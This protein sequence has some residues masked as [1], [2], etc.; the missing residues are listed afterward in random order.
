MR[1]RGRF[2]PVIAFRVVPRRR[3][4]KSGTA[5][6]GSVSWSRDRV[7]L[8]R[9]GKWV[10]NL[11]T[12]H[13]AQADSLR[14]CQRLRC[15][16]AR[17]KFGCIPCGTGRFLTRM[18]APSLRASACKIWLHSTRY[19]QI[20]YANASAFAAS[21]RVQNLA[22]FHA[23]QADSLRECQHLRCEQARA[24]FGCIPRG[25]GRFLTRMPAPS[26]RAGACKIW[27]HSLRYR[28]L[29]S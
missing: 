8:L 10:R 16:Q 7:F 26:L 27:L 25:A 6:Q 11:R 14:E 21:R 20:P 15:E 29:H 23:A 9:A 17:A 28:P 2:T 1:R 19:R 5:E 4:N 18:P 12:F 24:K 22:A 3:S 13:A